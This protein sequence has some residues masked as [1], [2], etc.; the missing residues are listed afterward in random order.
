MRILHTADWHLGRVLGG[1]D[2]IPAQRHAIEGIIA[3]AAD[4]RSDVIVVAGDLYDRA[5][6]GEEAVGLLDDALRRLGE[7]A[8]VLAIAGNHDS[9]ARL[10]FGGAFFRRAGVH[11]AGRPRACPLRVDLADA[12]GPVAFHLLPFATPADARYV[13]GCDHLP[14]HEAATAA[15]LAG[16]DTSAGGRHVLVGHLFVQGGESS[17]SER[18]ISVGGVATVPTGLFAPFHYTALGH[19]HRPHALADGRIRYAG[20]PARYSFS[21]EHQ[22]KTVALVTLDAA[23]GAS[24]EELAL[25]TLHGMRTL[26]GRFDDLVRAAAADA[27]RE[28]DLIRVEVVDPIVPPGARERLRALYP[29]LLEFRVEAPGRGPA[30]GARPALDDLARSSPHAFVERFLADRYP[31][32]ADDAVR[33]LAREC[34]EQAIAAERDR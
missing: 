16:A 1:L 8:P 23:G 20:S 15:L 34:M 14:S 25:P 28:R 10:D 19:L 22:C 18:D 21:E 31:G 12:H 27:D 4:T 9:G 32:A 30:D 26:R 3:I 7:I 6:P 5:V 11:I 29:L 33:A 13:T 24:V 2:L 17:D